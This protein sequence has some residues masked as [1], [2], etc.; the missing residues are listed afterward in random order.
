MNNKSKKMVKFVTVA[1]CA[2]AITVAGAALAGCGGNKSAEGSAT[3][4]AQLT[5]ANSECWMP[6]QVASMLGATTEVTV[7]IDGDNYTVTKIFACPDSEEGGAMPG[8]EGFSF[9]YTFTGA[10][11]SSDGDTYVLA[12]ATAC[13]YSVSWG[14]VAGVI[15]S[16]IAAGLPMT[17][18]LKRSSS[19]RRMPLKRSKATAVSCARCSMKPSA[20]S[21]SPKIPYVQPKSAPRKAILL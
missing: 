14:F 16:A 17:N 7:K 21:G 6:A 13:D 12:P 3:I 19:K 18:T 9:E 2:A 1:A 10:V 5:A 4:D 15:G 8:G 11:T 20:M